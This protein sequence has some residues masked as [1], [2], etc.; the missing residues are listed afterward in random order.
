MSR[1][2]DRLL[3]GD[4]LLLPLR[5]N[6]EYDQL[7]QPPQRPVG[8][9]NRDTLRPTRRPGAPSRRRPFPSEAPADLGA[10]GLSSGRAASLD[11]TLPPEEFDGLLEARVVITAWVEQYNTLRPHRGLGMMTPSAYAASCS[12]GGP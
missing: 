11:P 4:D 10:S 3:R 7:G 8:Q 6:A 12:E 9:R 1:I 5:A 2:G